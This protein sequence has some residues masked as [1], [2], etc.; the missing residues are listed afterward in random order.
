[1]ADGLPTIDQIDPELVDTDL[2]E[3]DDDG[4]LIEVE[5]GDIIAVPADT[6]D[7][8]VEEDAPEPDDEPDPRDVRIA[9]LEAELER[10]RSETPPADVEDAPAAREFKSPYVGETVVIDGVKHKVVNVHGKGRISVER[11]LQT[12]EVYGPDDYELA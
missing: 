2:T 11:D 3:F 5:T 9:E 8:D 6:D 4:N 12:R 7:E 10:A 1:M